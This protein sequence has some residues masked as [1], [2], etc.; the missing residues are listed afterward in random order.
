MYIENSPFNFTIELQFVFLNVSYL[1]IKRYVTHI[2]FCFIIRFFHK[3][4]IILKYS[5]F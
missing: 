3:E 2:R 4:E 5:A 1:I